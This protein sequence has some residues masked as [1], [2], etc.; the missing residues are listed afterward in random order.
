MK[1]FDPL[2]ESAAAAFPAATIFP[3]L[4]TKE[5]VSVQALPAKS[6][7]SVAAISTTALS[8]KASVNVM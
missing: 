8:A 1:P 3:V 4:C 5:I 2:K 7:T 6:F